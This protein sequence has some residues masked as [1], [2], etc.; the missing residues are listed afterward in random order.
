M[1][2]LFERAAKAPAGRLLTVDEAP[3]RAF[4]NRRPFLLRHELCGHPLFA[5]ERIVELARA[6]PEGLVEHYAGDVPRS[7]EWAHTPKNGFS[8]EETLR[9]IERHCSWMVL[10]RVDW[11]Q[12]YR[13]LLQRCLDEL[14]PLVEGVEPGMRERAG[15]LFVSSPGAVTPYHMDVEHNFLVQLQGSKRVHV[16]P[17]ADRSILSEQEIEEH[18]ARGGPNRNLVFRERYDGKAMVFE[19]RPGWALHIPS[20]DPHWVENGPGV[21]VSFSLG[22]ITRHTERR[23]AVHAVNHRLRRLGLQPRPYGASPLVDTVKHL[24]SWMLGATRRQLQRARKRAVSH[25]LEEQPS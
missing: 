20:L 6:M 19:L 15:A 17:G 13:A 24:C 2:S 23:V 21:S 22:F 3:F 7:L 5:L 12:A 25:L 14:V 9:H 4:L 11:D 8:V 10:K 16:Y 18:L 1:S